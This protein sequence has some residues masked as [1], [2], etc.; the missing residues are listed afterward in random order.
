MLIDTTQIQDFFLESVQKENLPWEEC[1]DKEILVPFAY[2]CL[3]VYKKSHIS[4]MCAKL[5]KNKKKD[6]SPL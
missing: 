6:K 5:K 2:T 3:A 1:T 4:F